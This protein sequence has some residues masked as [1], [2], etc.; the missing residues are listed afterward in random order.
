MATMSFGEALSG[1]SDVLYAQAMER[2]ADKRTVMLGVPSVH[3]NA[4]A[5]MAFDVTLEKGGMANISVS[6]YCAGFDL[7][8]TATIQTPEPRT[9]L[10]GHI[11][12]SDGGGLEFGEVRPDQPLRFELK[13]NLW[14][15][16]T[17]TLH[18]RTTPALPEGTVLK[19]SMDLHY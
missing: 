9:L 7:A 14:R 6:R 13:T 8:C 3:A 2:M 11:H 17:F 4:R 12:S 15:R 16:T 1:I 18:L 5:H 10:S 19:V